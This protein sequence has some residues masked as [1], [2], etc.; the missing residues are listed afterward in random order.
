MDFC[1]RTRK[2]LRSDQY[3][4]GGSTEY[5][6]SC[7]G[8]VAARLPGLVGLLDAGVVQPD[9]TVGEANYFF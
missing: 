9:G 2:L 6:F 3:F 7:D 8:H 5:L 1:T 4:L